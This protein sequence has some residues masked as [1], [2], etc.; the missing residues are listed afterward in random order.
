MVAGP[1]GAGKTNLLEAL[2][3]GCTARSPRTSNE[4]EL[5]RRGGEGVARVVLDT[6]R[7]GR[8]A[9]DRGRLRARRGEA[10]ARGRQPCRQPGGGRGAP[11]RERLPAGAARARE[12]RPGRRAG[13]TS[14]RW[15]PRSGRPAR[16]RAAPTRARWRS[17][18]RWWRGSAPGAA[19]PAALDAWDAELAR[20]G[21][22]ADGR[23]APRRWT[24]CAPLFAELAARL[25]L[26]GDGR[27]ALPAALCRR[28]TP[29]P[30][31]G[32]AERRTADLERGFTAH[33]PHRDE[34]AAAA[35]RRRR[36]G[37]TARR[38][39]SAR[40][41]RAAVRRAGAARRA[42]RPRRR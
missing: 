4:R 25:G 6:R 11:A 19:G 34:L 2:Y 32:A 39:S 20:H 21:I 27:A 1:N 5:V 29:R 42:P 13:P 22:A 38:A 10:P 30:R 36:C 23:T 41:A 16:R 35:R 17:A 33:G 37:H 18:T 8:R 9:P 31:R 40:A 14:T 24:A 12:G 26:P 7:R 3:F 28:R 15:S